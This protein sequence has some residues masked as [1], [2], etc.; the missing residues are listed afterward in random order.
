MLDV[1]HGAPLV[2]VPGIQARWEWLGP[3]IDALARDFR[4]LTYTLAGDPASVHRFDPRLGFDNFVVQIDRVLDRAGV[5]RAIVCGVSY[6]GL[7]ALRYAALRAERARALVLVSPLAPGWE[8]DRRVRFYSRAPLLLAP[9]FCLGS[10]RRMSAELRA[11]IPNLR[12]RALFSAGQLRRVVTARMSPR[13]MVHR[14][15]LLE[16]VDFHAA[17][18]RVTCP[19]LVVSGDGRLDSVV[20]VEHSRT[21]AKVLPHAEFTVLENSGHLGLVTMPEVFAGRVR[22]FVHRQ[23]SSDDRRLHEAVG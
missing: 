19:A 12:Q 22:A 4:V 3:A 23:L 20:P 17:A 2:L 5:D 11:S 1:G 15:G 10:A 9:L 6:G 7:V 14:I 13:H 8:P 21:Y 16:G 18:R